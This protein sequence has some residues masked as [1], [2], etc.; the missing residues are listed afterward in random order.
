MPALTEKQVVKVLRKIADPEIPTSIYDVGLIYSINI[1]ESDDVR[2]VMT[3]TSPTCPVAGSLP[4]EVERQL[5]ELPGVG[6]VRVE[7]TWDPP[8]SMD[9]M[10][11][12]ARLELG[13]DQHIPGAKLIRFGL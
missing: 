6:Q 10:S 7:V 5:R 11:E 13:L 4:G 1:S 2:V 8:W 3:L 12:A 9:R